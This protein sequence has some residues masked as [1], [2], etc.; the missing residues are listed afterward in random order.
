MAQPQSK[1][2]LLN[3]SQALMALALSLAPLALV[4]GE[5]AAPEKASASESALVRYFSQDYMLG[6]WGG[7]RTDLASNGVDFELFYIGAM[8]SNLS[9]GIRTG[10]SYQHALLLAMD[11]D[12]AKLGLWE[13][14]RLHLSGIWLEGTPF[15]PLHVGDVNKSS[16]VDLGEY[17]RPWSSYFE[18]KLLNDKLTIRAGLLTVDNDFIVAELYNSFAG[19]SFLNQTFFFPSLAFNVYEI[20]GFPVQNHSLAST[21]IPALGAV[22]KYQ[23]TPTLYGQVGVYEGNPDFS[24]N[25]NHMNVSDDEGALIY[26]EF[27]YRRNQGKNDT[28]LPGNIKVGGYLHTDDFLDI[29][30]T[31]GSFFGF[32]NIS[33]HD[34]NYGGYLLIDQMLYREKDKSDPAQQGLTGFFRLTGAPSDRNPAQFGI[35]GGVVYKGLIPGRDY[36]TLG[37][38]ASYLEWSRDLKR[39]QRAANAVVPG[40]FVV[41]DYEGVVEL[42]Y[43]M[44]IAAWWTLQ[45]SIQYCMHPGG[46]KAVDNA[47]VFVLQTTLRF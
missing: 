14:G 1:T 12:T 45:P 20:P 26:L 5:P 30:D 6:T 40:A 9:G 18:Q 43:K 13:G 2:S 16:L 37:L 15:S 31:I 10:T 34:Y 47:V 35:D 27:G 25:G 17:L 39:A 32:A 24:Y 8:P 22:V 41:S 11:F 21:P 33:S 28:G 38:A 42:S 23:I 4:A 46:S 36:D 3:L 29:Y 19:L 44:Q 7:L